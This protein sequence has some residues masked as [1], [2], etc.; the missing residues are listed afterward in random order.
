M[1]D[2][3]II[4]IYI[5]INVDKVCKWLDMDLDKLDLDKVD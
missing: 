4:D 3:S 5:C 2:M 1:V